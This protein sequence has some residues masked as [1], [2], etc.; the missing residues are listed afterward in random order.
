MEVQND[1]DLLNKLN[2]WSNVS[3]DDL[4]AHVFYQ[5]SEQTLE[6]F[7]MFYKDY[8]EN[9][10]S[11]ENYH[12]AFVWS[13]Q[14]RDFSLLLRD[15]LLSLV[16]YEQYI[17]DDADVDKDFVLNLGSTIKQAALDILNSRAGN[18]LSDKELKQYEHQINPISIILEQVEELNIQL[19]KIYRSHDKVNEIRINLESFKREFY[20][21]FQKQTSFVESLIDHID[22]VAEQISAI[23]PNGVKE[24]ISEVIDRINF[25]YSELEI[26]QGIESMEVLSYPEKISLNV[27][28]D[29]DSGRLI[30]KALDIQSE[31]SKWFSGNVYPHI[32]E[33]ENRRN[34][35]LEASL[36][37]LNHAR[38]KLAA[39]I[40]DEK[41]SYDT[42]SSDVKVGITELRTKHINPLQKEATENTLKI[43]KYFDQDFH[44]SSIYDETSLF[45]PN[46]GSVQMTN[47]SRDAQKRMVSYYKKYKTLSYGWVE[48]SLAKYIELDRI[49]HN[50]YISNKLLIN[51]ND[52]RLS[53]FLKKG[54]L[55]K[56]FS[57][58]RPDLIEPI[59]NDYQLWKSGYAAAILIFGQSGSGKSA[60]MGMLSQSAMIDEMVSVNAGEPYFTKNKSFERSYDLE[61][62]VTHIAH[63]YIGQKV[64]LT[65]DDLGQWHNKKYN[66]FDNVS[67]LFALIQKFKEDIFFIVSCNSYLKGRIGIF[68]D[69]NLFFSTQVSVS[70]LS[71]DDIKE[72]LLMR[73]RALPELGLSDT[74]HENT[75]SP[76]LRNANGNIGHAMMEYSRFY[77][78]EY[79]PDLKSQEFVELV[80]D[81][82]T[83]LKY[84]LCFQS[85]DKNDLAKMLTDIELTDF[86]NH[87]RYL[88]GLKVLV[89]TKAN[90]V[91]VNPFLIYSVE[92]ALEHKSQT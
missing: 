45:M 48:R 26:L 33:L 52:E 8:S 60:L 40:L 25:S 57:V 81:H 72:A 83:I 19:K 5:K 62:V 20:L 76:I 63:Q 1:T 4:T 18:S 67:A 80:K 58:V 56:S 37:A 49:P 51:K 75:I 35:A 66:L 89:Y 36:A 43:E 59:I 23:H 24:K 85:I 53:L 13:I 86:M 16:K 82:K 73:F 12:T 38:V 78:S 32:I 2:D 6:A 44:A 50:S 87:I 90:I 91:T 41:D 22:D 27:P 77:N 17:N 55:G 74:G 65:I 14:I 54:Y 29:V 70:K 15:S 88:I 92:K 42:A 30:S 71:N 39:L 34:L 64:I 10:I 9:E 47:I 84:I 68:R 28:V 61:K 69:L 31:F 7:S 3:Q 21:S 79:K 11:N 46:N